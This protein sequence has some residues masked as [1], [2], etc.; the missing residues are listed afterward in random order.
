M[1]GLRPMPCRQGSVNYGSSASTSSMANAG[2]GEEEVSDQEQDLVGRVEDGA[3]GVG[4]VAIPD[5][6]DSPFADGLGS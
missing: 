6:R 4:P 3:E 5:D 1:V 2:V